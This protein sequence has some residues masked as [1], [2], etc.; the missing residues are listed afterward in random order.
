MI[1]PHLFVGDKVRLIRTTDQ[2]TK[3][4]SGTQGIVSFID[5]LGTIHVNWDDGSTLGLIPNVDSYE[6]I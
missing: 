1:S 2:Y 6:R 4:Q 3:I 5:D